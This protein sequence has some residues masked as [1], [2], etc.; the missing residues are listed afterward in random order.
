MLNKKLIIKQ[1]WFKGTGDD[2][3]SRIEFDEKTK[4]FKSLKSLEEES[5]NLTNAL[6]DCL[7][8]PI[9]EN[10]N[11][12]YDRLFI[13]SVKGI[14]LLLA[15]NIFSIKISGFK[16]LFKELN[17]A[18][19]I[20]R[21]QNIRSFVQTLICKLFDT[22]NQRITLCNFFFKSTNPMNY[23]YTPSTRKLIEDE[24]SLTLKNVV[25]RTQISV[26]SKNSSFI[27]DLSKENL[28][29]IDVESMNKNLE[30]IRNENDIPAGLFGW[31]TIC[32]KS[33]N[34]YCKEKRIPICSYECKLKNLDNFD[35]FTKYVTFNKKEEKREITF[36]ESY[37]Q[38]FEELSINCFQKNNDKEKTFYLDI[39]LDMIKTPSTALRRDPLF[40]L[41]IKKDVLPYLTKTTFHTDYNIL[42]TSLIIFLNL[43]FNFRK[44]LRYEIGIYI[45]EVFL[46]ILESVNSKFIYKYYILQVLTTLIEEKSIPFELFLNYDCKEGSFNICEQIIDLLVKISQGK[47]KKNVYLSMINELEEEKLRK[48]A[49][50]AIIHLITGCSLFLKEKK[51]LEENE[52]ICPKGM[53]K[54][55]EKKKDIE[56]AFLKFNAGKKSGMKALK[57]LGVIKEGPENMAEFL[58][59]DK[60][61]S[62]FVIGEIF[63]GEDDFNLQVLDLYLEKL[64]FKNITVLEA[65]RFFL[66]LFELPGEG[67]KVER[68][69]DCFSKKY[70]AD[71]PELTSDAAHLLS[72]LLMM[73]HTNTYNPQVK[74]K[75]IL[76]DFLNIGKHINNND[77]PFPVEELTKYYHDISQKPIA[78]HSLEKRKRDI[79]NIL[80]SSL[81]K[82]QELFEMESSKLLE[83]YTSKIQGFEVKQ[84]WRFLEDP[85]VVQVFIS[86]MWTNL[87]AFFSTSIANAED[88]DE[89]RALVDSTMTM[90]KLSDVFD[91]QKERDSFINLLV[92]FSGLEKTFNNLFDEKHLLLMQAIL[93]IATKMGNHLN[94][95]WKFVLNC[96]VS[97]NYYQIQADKID[98]I[99]I[100]NQTLSNAE[101]NSFFVASYFTK[102]DLNK[103]FSDTDKLNEIS[104]L[105]FFSGLTEIALKEIESEG[106]RT[107]YILEQIVVVMNFNIHRNPLEWLRIW[108]LIDD[109]Y[110]K[111]IEKNSKSKNKIIIF[112]IDILRQ[113]VLCCF[114]NKHILQNKYQNKIF[115]VYTTICSNKKIDGVIV[116]YLLITFK[117]VMYK[118]KDDIKGGITQIISTL[119]LCDLCTQTLHQEF[120]KQSNEIS[121]EI[122]SLITFIF[123]NLDTFS[124]YLQN[125]FENILNLLSQ[126]TKKNFLPVVIKSLDLQDDIF[127]MFW[128]Q[129]NLNLK[130]I[131][132]SEV[133]S[134][135]FNHLTK[136]SEKIYF[137]NENIYF[138]HFILKTL[139]NLIDFEVRIITEQY[140]EILNKI[141]EILNKTENFLLMDSWEMLQEKIL[142]KLLQKLVNIYIENPKN[143]EDFKEIFL[144]VAKSNFAL[145]FSNRLKPVQLLQVYFTFL[146]SISKNQ[147][148]MILDCLT[149]NLNDIILFTAQLEEDN[150]WISEIWEEIIKYL[151]SLFSDFF[152]YELTKNDIWTEMENVYLPITFENLKAKVFD[153]RD[154][155]SY[156]CRFILNLIKLIQIILKKTELKQESIDSLFTIMEKFINNSREFNKFSLN[157]FILWK[158]GYF[159]DKDSLPSLY[160]FENNVLLA[161]FFYYKKNFKEDNEKIFDFIIEIYHQYFEELKILNN[162]LTNL[163]EKQTLVLSEND[164]NEEYKIKDFEEKQTA[165]IFYFNLINDNISPFLLSL[166]LDTLEMIPVFDSLIE[167]IIDFL[168]YSNINSLTFFKCIK[169]V[170]CENCKIKS[171]RFKETK[172]IQEFLKNLIKKKNKPL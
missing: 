165:V 26:E 81:K 156:K 168:S 53:K 54:V 51:N 87:L 83:N 129:D 30:D 57:E 66:S 111:I 135:N 134:K 44:H 97:L 24:V 63:G 2:Y 86:T 23:F 58:A 133:V 93:S 167:V 36:K 91:M 126:L 89:L 73:L 163:E 20:A 127:N 138:Q 162:S 108:K 34:F 9:K 37:I 22:I 132:F 106:S 94:T 104:I 38:I 130:N 115:S 1:R 137:S 13:K 84:D 107:H 121:M 95:G 99:K 140:K 47:Y 92:Q 18:S 124:G 152:P 142:S 171:K 118:L 32:R 62:H 144:F 65:L 75:M 21:N 33:A 60:R 3:V 149:L 45:Q 68:I 11:D 5:R 125:D 102:D 141:F 49:R 123:E 15:N 25:D 7:V 131:P 6:I 39:L 64:N 151:N 145:I 16:D 112:S 27:T 28:M 90:I 17:R 41:F 100:Q 154:F 35:K 12:R 122:L 120:N 10:Y 19:V 42:K 143:V 139:E 147:N 153:S 160:I 29:K 80:S 161:K 55:I 48:E 40:I 88:Q 136:N 71:N 4:R 128:K 67:Q 116:D 76:A 43:V 14:L 8:F 157:R 169:C 166:D 114:R 110:E 46:Q 56:D 170:E 117:S 70:S 119:I 113:L 72:V 164:L 78:I 103:I 105:N 50:E 74:E 52:Q 158:K 77:K 148:K 98:P 101:K 59:T 155:T 150:P 82:K 146:H 79:Q 172:P 31:C 109:L 61:C 159:S 85:S 96:I 69:L